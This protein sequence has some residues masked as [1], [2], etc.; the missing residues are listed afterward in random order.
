MITT[1]KRHPSLSKSGS[2][3]H[4]I[5]GIISR[6]PTLLVEFESPIAIAL[7]RL[8]QLFSIAMSGSQL[9]SPWPSAMSM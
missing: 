8:N 4:A 1:V 5:A 7:R 6:V 2:I 3:A 9:P